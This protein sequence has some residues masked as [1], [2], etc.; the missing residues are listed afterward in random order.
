MIKPSNNLIA[1]W[2]NV[3]PNV[4]VKAN[5]NSLLISKKTGRDIAKHTNNM[6]VIIIILFFIVYSPYAFYYIISKT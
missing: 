5:K 4:I 2:Y 3:T 6:I 1:K